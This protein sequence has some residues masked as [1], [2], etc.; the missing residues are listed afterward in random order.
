MSSSSRLVNQHLSGKIFRRCSYA[1]LKKIE[2]VNPQAS[3]NV[4]GTYLTPRLLLVVPIL[5]S[6]VNPFCCRFADVFG[7]IFLLVTKFDQDCHSTVKSFLLND[8]T[9]T[10]SS[11]IYKL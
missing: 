11:I 4:P 5:H 10:R 8:C 7:I 6:T 3:A 2:L 1:P 9:V